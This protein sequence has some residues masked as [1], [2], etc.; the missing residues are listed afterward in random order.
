MARDDIV[1]LGW[2]CSAGIIGLSVALEL[3]KRGYGQH[4]TVVAEH[5]P[6]D[7]DIKYT[8]PW[9]GANFSGISGSNA[10][11]LRW[12][13]LGYSTMMELVDRGAEEAKYLSKT[14]S[15]EYWDEMPSVDK[16]RSMTEYLRDLVQIPKSE[17]PKGVSFGIKFTTI[18]LNAPAHCQHLQSLLSQPKYG[19][20]LFVRRNVARLKD[21]F[22]SANTRIVFNCI[23]NT[24]VSFPDVMDSKCYPTRG[25]I[26]LVKAPAV[27]RNMM[28]HGRNYETYIIP[29]PLSDS[30][31]ILGGYMQKGNWDSQAKPH[32]TE[33]ILKRTGDLLPVLKN[34]ETKVLGVAVGLRPSREGGARVELEAIPQDG[35]VV[36]HNYGAGGTGFQAGLGMAKDAVDLAAEELGKIKDRSRL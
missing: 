2:T 9:A 27:K 29:R 8:S 4:I 3:S 36:V 31:V 11:A 1:I 33:S 28:R 18:T 20:V 13:R 6:G 21:A 22:L 16:I 17:L 7:K 30:T 19:S 15:I 14:E 35:K 34:A 32:E 12:D 25:Q 10:N 23:G 5:L 24:A 26:V